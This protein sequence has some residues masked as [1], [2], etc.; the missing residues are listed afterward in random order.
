M[1]LR[2]FCDSLKED[3]RI[4]NNLLSETDWIA[5]EKLLNVLEPFYKC[6]LRLQAQSHTLSDFY[7]NW[8]HI[9]IKLQKMPDSVLK[10]NIVE[11]MDIRKTMLLDNPIML[12]A[13]YLDPRYQRTLDSDQRKLAIFFLTG[14]YQ[15]LVNLEKNTNENVTEIQNQNLE[16]GNE[17]D[18]FED[19]VSFLHS[20]PN[21]SSDNQVCDHT[22]EI[23]EK[24]NGVVEDLR[25]PVL[26]YWEAKKA[27]TVLY[28]LSQVIFAVPPTQTT[29]ERA[30]SALAL[31]LISLRTRI[32]DQNLQN[33][34]IVRLNR[35]IIKEVHTDDYANYC[36]DE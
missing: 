12:S 21:G 17:S 1:Q 32:S 23:L 11:Q 13:I 16:N 27:Q 26:Q 28:K 29:V 19:L 35:D 14:V 33:I 6:S 36:N 22:T 3:N 25:T 15:K 8:L 4:K 24:F 2:V 5:V 10:T 9:T 31:I 34:L 30:F 7:G 20:I 18:S